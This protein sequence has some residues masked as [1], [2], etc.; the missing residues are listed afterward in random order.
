MMA[1]QARGGVGPLLF[2]V[3]VASATP[4]RVLTEAERPVANPLIAESTLSPGVRDS[5]LSV[6]EEWTQG[7]VLSPRSIGVEC[8]LGPD[9]HPRLG[10]WPGD[11]RCGP[12]CLG[13]KTGIYWPGMLLDQ[14]C[15][16]VFIASSPRSSVCGL[17][18]LSSWRGSALR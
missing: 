18:P 1:D 3:H 13:V 8:P 12:M 11:D 6:M 9:R 4:W 15:S 14:A 16:L 10:G 5:G 17:K 2:G 7:D